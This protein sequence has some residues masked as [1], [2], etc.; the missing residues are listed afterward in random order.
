MLTVQEAGQANRRIPDEEVLQFA[1]SQDRAVITQ[2]RRDFIKL[3]NQSSAHAG[4]G[5]WS[6]KRR[7]IETLSGREVPGWIASDYT[8]RS[9]WPESSVC[10]VP[11]VA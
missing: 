7:Y 10:P 6:V 9:P 11:S 3:H 5:H 1:I 8:S 4:I 2:N